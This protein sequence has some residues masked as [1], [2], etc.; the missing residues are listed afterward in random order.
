MPGF[1]FQPPVIAH[2]GVSAHA[3]ENTMAAMRLVPASGAKWIEFDVHIT[4]D[5]VPVLLHDDTLDRTTNGKGK[6]ADLDWAALETLDA[7][8]WFDARFKNERAPR[9]AD[10]L[11]FALEAGLRPL[12]EIKPCPGRAQATTMVALMEAAK[13]WPVNQPP[14]F[15]LSFDVDAVA[16]AAQF[17]PHWPRGFSFSRWREDWRLFAARAQA[18][19][20]VVDV[21]F[22][23]RARVSV[24]AQGG[25]P[26]LAYTVN[27]PAQA[28]ELL[29]WGVSAVFSDNPKAIIEAL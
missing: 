4:E 11:R 5:G 19:M 27:D 15:I 23:N 26:L 16:I 20:L 2:R 28:K 1:S 3:P 21:D 18:D 8:S 13:V 7:G 12:I 9:L 6:I 29:D 10:A 22:L 14:P 24:M 17:Q 25:L